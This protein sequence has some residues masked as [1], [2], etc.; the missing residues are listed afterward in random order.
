MQFKDSMVNTIAMVVSR[1]ASTTDDALAVSTTILGVD[2]HFRVPDGH[3]E[4]TC[5]QA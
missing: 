2:P 4:S 3:R 5:R 1:R